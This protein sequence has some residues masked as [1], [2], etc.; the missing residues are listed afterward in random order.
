MNVEDRVL[1]PVAEVFAAIVDHEKMS[2]YFIT[3]ADGPMKA[4]KTVLWEFSDVGYKVPIDV[5][6]VEVNRKIVFEHTSTNDKTRVT[7]GL[8]SV[9]SNTTLVAIN[10]AGWPMEE[11]GVKRAL[12]QT[13]GWTF[14]LCCLKAYLQFGINLRLGL[15]HRLTKQ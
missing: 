8:K 3:G 14:F 11:D 2:Q 5:I 4:G 13:A 7:I 15:T 1:K 9:D 6:A 12:G 10:E